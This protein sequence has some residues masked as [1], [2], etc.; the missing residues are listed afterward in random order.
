MYVRFHIVPTFLYFVV[1][2]LYSWYLNRPF[3]QQWSAFIIYRYSN[4]CFTPNHKCCVFFNLTLQTPKSDLT[5]FTKLT[6]YL[7]K[8]VGRAKSRD[9][10]M[11]RAILVWLSH[12]EVEKFTSEEGTRDTPLGFLSLLGQKR[13][14][15][16][17][18]FTLLC[19]YKRNLLSEYND[20]YFCFCFLFVNVCLVLVCLRRLWFVEI[21]HLIDWV[22]DY[23]V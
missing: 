4:I 16:S 3:W 10:I 14:T 19:R 5:S 21:C 11:V 6:K 15:Y 8:R 17:T 13:S 7:E 20:S 1:F 9:E 2:A 23:D 22:K 18:F 12:Q